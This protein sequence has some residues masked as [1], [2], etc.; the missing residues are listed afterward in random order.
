MARRIDSWPAT[1][2]LLQLAQKSA[3]RLFPT[4]IP[5]FRS[6]RITISIQLRSQLFANKGRKSG[7]RGGSFFLLQSYQPFKI[8]RKFAS[9]FFIPDRQRKFSPIPLCSKRN[10]AKDRDS[11]LRRKK[12]GGELPASYIQ[13]ISISSSTFLNSGSPV[14][15]VAF[16]SIA[17]TRAKQSAYERVYCSTVPNVTPWILRA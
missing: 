17:E 16:C 8:V 10:I 1:S 3:L 9:L 6:N 2:F 14:T 15:R 5:I 12:G 13:T 4:Y 11:H 7:G